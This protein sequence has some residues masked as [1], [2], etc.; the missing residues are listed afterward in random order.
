MADWNEDIS[1]YPPREIMCEALELAGLKIGLQLLGKHFIFSHKQESDLI[2]LLGTIIGVQ[3][4]DDMIPELFVSVP[5]FQ[6]EQL[7]SLKHIKKQE[8][9]AQLL[10]NN[11]SFRGV[12]EILD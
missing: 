4:S 12:L 6:T 5:F 10:E 7:K 9:A 2:I 3:L 11:Q 1:H 8:W